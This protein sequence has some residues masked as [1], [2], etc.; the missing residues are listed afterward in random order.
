MAQ[1]QTSQL[2]R[3]GDVAWATMEKLNCELL[4]L[5]YG[6]MV[7]QLLEDYQDCKI[8]SVELEKLGYSVGVRLVDEFLAKSGVES[9]RSFQDTVEAVGK[10]GFRM[11]LGISAEVSAWDGDKACSLVFK[12]NPLNYF[13]ELPTNC[14][15]LQ[16]SN[17]LCGVIRG[18]L[19]M[20][21][22]IVECTYVQSE[23]KGEVCEIRIVLK[24]IVK[25]SFQD[26]E[27]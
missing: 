6:A 4:A 17:L 20:V 3:K 22:L 24:E 27:D 18:A 13:V 1:A 26:S 8:V 16:Y 19:A 23:L 5:T 10:V 25:E 12:G 2:S 15:E 21:N 7:A 14:S 9:C 11:F